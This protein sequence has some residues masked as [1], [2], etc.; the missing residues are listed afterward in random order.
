MQNESQFGIPFSTHRRHSQNR[1]SNLEEC[2]WR[3]LFSSIDFFPV[4]VA[5]HDNIV[6]FC[7]EDHAIITDAERV[8]TEFRVGLPFGV[9]DWIIFEAKEVGVDALFD[10][11][12]MPV[13]VSDG[14]SRTAQ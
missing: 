10:T 4:T 1:S 11:G 14:F 2:F 12:F 8:A 3:L 7:I 13:N 9:L 5:Q 6:A